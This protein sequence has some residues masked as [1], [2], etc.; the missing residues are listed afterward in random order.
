[1]AIQKEKHKGK[2]RYRFRC[3]FDT[4]D[5]IHRQKSS[6]WYETKREAEAAQRKFLST[7]AQPIK[8]GQTF[9]KLMDEWILVGGRDNT[10]ATRDDK[11]RILNLYCQSIMD[12]NAFTITPADIKEIL[13]DEHFTQLS[14][15]RKNKLYTDLNGCL[16]YGCIHWGLPK[17]PIK[18]F[19]RYKE[20]TEEK[21]NEVVILD[22]YQFSEFLRAIPET[23]DIYRKLFFWLYWTGMRA[24]EAMS[25][26]FRDIQGTRAKVWRQWD[27][28]TEQFKMLKTKGSSRFV[29]LDQDL[30]KVFSDLRTYYGSFKGF[31]PDWFIFGGPRQLAYTTVQRVKNNALDKAGLPRVKIHSFRHSHASN[32]IDAGVPIFKIS[33]RLGH[34]SVSMTTDI[35]GHLIRDDDDDIL[36]AMKIK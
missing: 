21:L 22:K 26:T 7:S 9:A 17:N 31:S 14:S 10:A 35:Y 1:M 32:L 2:M 19:S 20:T 15:Y 23:H 13:E 33:K 16:E 3:Y 29:Q 25:L 11:R 4:P 6:R 27:R 5:G 24:N 8:K 18:G 34:S 36:N 28:D 30:M 12:K